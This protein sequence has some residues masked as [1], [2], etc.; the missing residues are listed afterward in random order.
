[1]C[2]VTDYEGITEDEEYSGN[3]VRMNDYI[4]VPKGFEGTKKKIEDIGYTGIEV[5]MSEFQKQD[6]GL[7]CLSLRF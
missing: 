3:C 4:I 2:L 6:G 7:S 1:M 5:E